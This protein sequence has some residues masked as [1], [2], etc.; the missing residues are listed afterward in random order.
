MAWGRKSK[1]RQLI[2]KEVSD[3]TLSYREENKQLLKSY[4]ETQRRYAQLEDSIRY[5][6]NLQNALFPDE[7]KLRNYFNDSFILSIP[8]DFLSGDFPWFARV[9]DKIIIAVADCTGHGIPGALMSVM[10]LSFLN[11]SVFDKGLSG[12]S[13]ILKFVDKRMRETF[14]Y[15]QTS[16]N[17]NG[18]DGMDITICSIDSSAN[19]IRLS[20]AMQSVFIVRDHHLLEHKT[21][22]YPVGGLALE[23]HRDFPEKTIIFDKNDLL[24]LFTDGYCDQFGG[25]YNRKITKQRF[26][27]MIEYIAPYE[28]DDQKTQLQEFFM[29][30]K[31]DQEQ[32]DDVTVIGIRL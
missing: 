17:R 5:A 28:I 6:A 14:S 10:G 21:S 23:Q 15:H 20:G 26:K 18:Y 1:I 27:K 22:R 4:L 30:W 2:H 9:H 19:T 24:Y 29:L 32:T 3:Q 7:S 25:L 13:E 11:E 31:Q 8:K 16:Q 12:P